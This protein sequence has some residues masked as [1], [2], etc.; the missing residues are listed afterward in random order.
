MYG[1]L[2]VYI[3]AIRLCFYELRIT[4]LA[5]A[6]KMGQPIFVRAPC[7]IARIFFARFLFETLQGD[8]GFLGGANRCWAVAGFLFDVEV[9]RISRKGAVRI[10]AE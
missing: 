4:S 1:V 8:D 5:R 9:V 6:E 10:G 2:L 3:V 7:G